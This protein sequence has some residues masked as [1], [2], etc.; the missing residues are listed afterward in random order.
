MKGIPKTGLGKW[1][2]GLNGFFLVAMAVSCGLVL[3]FKVIN[4][5][6]HWLDFTVGITFPASIIALVTGILAVGKY[7]EHSASVYASIFVGIST[8]LFLL[9]HSLFIND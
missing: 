3:V 9:L 5:N 2:V 8:V 1:S 4:F 7:K 6:D